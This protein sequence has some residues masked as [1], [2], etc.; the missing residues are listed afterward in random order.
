[1]K[2][3][4]FS[5]I[6]EVLSRVVS[7]ILVLSF[8][9]VFFLGKGNIILNGLVGQGTLI[10][11]SIVLYELIAFVFYELFCFIQSKVTSG[12]DLEAQDYAENDKAQT[13]N[14]ME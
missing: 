8:Y 5:G 2:Q 12:D 11:G 7:L 9:V 3:D 10:L 1:M 13:I 6:S 4:F 14:S